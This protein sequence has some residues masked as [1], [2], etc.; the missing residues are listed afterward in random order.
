MSEAGKISIQEIEALLKP[1]SRMAW[2]PV[3]EDGENSKFLSKFSGK[4]MLLASEVWPCCKNCKQPMQLFIQLDSKELP[5]EAD[6]P[7]GE[8]YLQVFYCTNATEECDIECEAYFPFSNST[9]VRVLGFNESYD[10][11][12]ITSEVKDQLP[13]K[14]ITSWL[15]KIDYPSEQEFDDLEINLTDDQSDFALDN[16][17][18]ALP[19]DKLLGW[20]LWIQGPEY[21]D[22]PICDERM[23][24]VLQIDSE[25][26]LDFMFG[27]SGCSHI[28]QCKTH[29]DQL[30]IAWACC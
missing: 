14:T 23:D 13:Q 7:F 22:C 19:K 4:P 21:P 8:G 6:N 10:T 25:D 1:H 11:D 30:T 18:S 3:V 28:T 9:L 20:P 17:I 26:N 29:R 5:K 27:D 16:Q 15:E 2:Y 12:T 24:Y